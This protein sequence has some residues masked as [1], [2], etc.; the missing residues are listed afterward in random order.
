M[1]VVIE[2]SSMYKTPQGAHLEDG[3]WH[4]IYYNI[5]S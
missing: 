5:M 3:D 4:T 1:G 2:I